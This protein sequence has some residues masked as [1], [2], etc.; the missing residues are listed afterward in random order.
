[1]TSIPGQLQCSGKMYSSV[2]KMRS[3]RSQVLHI[4]SNTRSNHIHSGCNGH[5]LMLPSS[6]RCGRQ[7]QQMAS[8]G[9]LS[10][11]PMCNELHV[12]TL[13]HTLSYSLNPLLTTGVADT[14]GQFLRSNYFT[15]TRAAQSVAERALRFIH[16][17]SHVKA[18]NKQ[19][20]F[21]AE[22]KYDCGHQTQST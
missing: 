5:F 6:L 3:T 15:I 12:G 20:C 16:I 21:F 7:L 2:P 19:Q 17:Q 11:P 18:L 1:V 14:M 4:I 8:F 9:S 22:C 13:Q 10:A